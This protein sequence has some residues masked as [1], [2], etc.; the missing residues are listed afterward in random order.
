MGKN[1]V[2]NKELRASSGIQRDCLLK[3]AYNIEGLQSIRAIEDD[4]DRY[5]AAAAALYRAAL[6]S[7]VPAED[8]K[9]Q[10]TAANIAAVAE[11][12]WDKADNTIRTFAKKTSKHFGSTEQLRQFAISWVSGLPEEQGDWEMD[13][14]LE[15]ILKS[16]EA[17]MKR[18]VPGVRYSNWDLLQQ[19]RIPEMT[20]ETA[21]LLGVY[22]GDSYVD[23][24]LNQVMLLGTQHDFP[25]YNKVVSPMI[26]DLF[27]L[28]CPAKQSY[29]RKFRM[30]SPKINISSQAHH[31]WLRHI[32]FPLNIDFKENGVL[33]KSF[34]AGIIASMGN[35]DPSQKALKIP[36]TSQPLLERIHEVASGIGYSPTLNPPSFKGIVFTKSDTRILARDSLGTAISYNHST[37]NGAGLYFNQRELE[38]LARIGVL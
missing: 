26:R 1:R 31:T 21:F 18:D 33:K 11:E 14:P 36:D 17:G 4:S 37:L 5:F 13:K 10:L 19:T 8:A 23:D 6:S 25:F 27:N 2:R 38:K 16:L 22:V 34:F 30:Y 3:D 24:D 15:E 32:G 7:G 35:I 12:S 9:A 20:P 29:S 28:N